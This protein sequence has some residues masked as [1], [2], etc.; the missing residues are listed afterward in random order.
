MPSGEANATPGP[1]GTVESV[2]LHDF[3]CHKGHITYYRPLINF[4]SGANGSGKS[5]IVAALQVG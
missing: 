2:T 1:L 3:M 5:A 4:V